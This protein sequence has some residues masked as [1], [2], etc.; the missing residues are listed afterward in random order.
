MAAD[1]GGERG[2]VVDIAGL[3]DTHQIRVAL[4]RLREAERAEHAD[5]ASQLR[6]HSEIEIK[7]SSLHRT[8]PKLVRC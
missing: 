4:E 6:R 7:M 5:L 2:G 8:A 1:G 3:T